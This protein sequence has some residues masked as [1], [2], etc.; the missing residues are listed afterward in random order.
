MTHDAHE[1]PARRARKPSGSRLLPVAAALTALATGCPPAESPSNECPP[2]G[3][4]WVRRAGQDYATA[5]LD[6]ARD[7]AQKAMAICPIGSTR[8]LAA[9]VALA[10]LDYDEAL[11]LLRGVRSSEAASVRG[12]ALWY[13]GELDAAA[14]ELEVMLDDP[15]VH[16]DWAKA[17]AK[18][19]RRG[20]GRR[21]F[22]LS[23]AL[24]APV[25]MP[26][27]SPIAPFFLVPLEIDGESALALVSTGTAEVVLD[28]ATRKEPSWVSLRF[29]G[30]LEVQ[31]VPAL[32]QDLAGLSKQVGAPIKALLGVN[33]LRH[34]HAT[35]DYQGRQFVVRSFSPPAPPR[36]TRVGLSYVRGGGM[37]IPSSFGSGTEG[38][39]SL[40][41]DTSTALPIAL[42]VAGW[43][44]AG[45][46]A[47]ALTP[48]ADDPTQKLREGVLPVVKLGS[49]EVPRVPAY[50][51]APVSEIEKALGVDIDGIAGAGLLA[52]FRLTLGEGGRA[53]WIEDHGPDAEPRRPAPAAEPPA[54]EPPAAPTSPSPPPKP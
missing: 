36:A 6:E 5:D 26:H 47:A 48:V 16:D 17:I 37:V 9:R 46:D 34:L 13:K 8:L 15:D 20:A 25:E 53:L 30:R 41:V 43:K 24:L 18:L 50:V 44:K 14:D 23:G 3:E 21:P 28:S 38:R 22:T 19:A 1:P 35:L 33:L 7:S 54:A 11:R 29:D 49:F 42:D 52:H 45:F 31:D 39:A 12:R 32:V 40:L 2:D 4:K 27:V 51:G 10:R